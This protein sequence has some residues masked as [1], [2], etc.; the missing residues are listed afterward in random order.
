MG[1]LQTLFLGG[2]GRISFLMNRES[3][4][5]VGDAFLEK[6]TYFETA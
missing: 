4:I 1:E 6:A 3:P 2:G 5:Y